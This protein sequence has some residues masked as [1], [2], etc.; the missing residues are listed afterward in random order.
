MS[1][2]PLTWAV[3]EWP[4]GLYNE[5]QTVILYFA[6]MIL[7]IKKQCKLLY[8]DSDAIIIS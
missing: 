2:V 4:A 6:A 3:Y 5:L 7:T 1:A 8:Q